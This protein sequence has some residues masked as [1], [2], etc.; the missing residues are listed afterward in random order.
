VNTL[1]EAYKLINRVNALAIESKPISQIPIPSPL[2]ANSE[3][4][5]SAALAEVCGRTESKMID[6]ARKRQPITA[7]PRFS[8]SVKPKQY[9][10]TVKVIILI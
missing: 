10:R 6:K 1:N 2:L 3:L 9:H 8:R 5:P 4:S 7:N